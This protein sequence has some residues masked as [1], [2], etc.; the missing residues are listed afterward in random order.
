VELDPEFF[1]ERAILGSTPPPAYQTFPEYV[2]RCDARLTVA[3]AAVHLHVC[4]PLNIAFSRGACSAVMLAHAP[5]MTD[6]PVIR[7]CIGDQG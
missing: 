2:A 7:S 1:T 3:D 5:Q 4:F 6:S